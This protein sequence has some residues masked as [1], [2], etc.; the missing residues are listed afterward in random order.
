MPETTEADRAR[1]AAE[2]GDCFGRTALELF[3]SR[4]F[5]RAHPWN[6]PQGPG[7]PAVE[8]ALAERHRRDRGQRPFRRLGGDPRLAEGAGRALRHRLP[9]A[10]EP[11]LDALYFDSVAHTGSPMLPKG[12]LAVR[13]LVRT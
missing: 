3:A 11:P 4:A 6:P 2:V 1:I 8:A 10:E 7:L 9:P 5:E 12:R 13:T